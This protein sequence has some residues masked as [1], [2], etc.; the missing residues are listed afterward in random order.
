MYNH[1]H[2]EKNMA[3]KAKQ[4]IPVNMVDYVYDNK[5]HGITWPTMHDH[6]Q[7]NTFNR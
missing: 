2:T 7:K 3:G 1:K 6:G 4:N 5:K